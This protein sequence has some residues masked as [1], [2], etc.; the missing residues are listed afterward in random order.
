MFPRICE[1]S[2]QFLRH[3]S[4]L[5][6]YESYYMSHIYV[7]VYAKIFDPMKVFLLRDILTSNTTHQ[8]MVETLEVAHRSKNLI[9]GS[10]SFKN[11][12]S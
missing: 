7:K 8:E 12:I 5:T 6:E 10:D 4:W 2:K 9:L 11:M 3:E 1:H